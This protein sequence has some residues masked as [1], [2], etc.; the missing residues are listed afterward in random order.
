ME[1]WQHI[2]SHFDPIAFK[3]FFLS[4]HW[5]GIMYALAL[6][7]AVMMASF[8]VKKDKLGISED[9]LDEYIIWA[10]VGVIL[11]A[12]LGYIV[13][14]DPHTYYFLTH[15]W[16][17]FNPF[18]GGTFV[19]IAGM[20]FHGAL[21]G[22]ILATLLYSRKI[23]KK[24]DKKTFWFFVDLAA[25]AVPLGYFFGR[26]GN[27]LNQEL[28]GRVTEV[29]W[30]I[31]VHGVLRHPSQIYEAFLEGVVVFILLYIY[32]NKKKFDGELGILFAI[33]YS[34]ARIIAEF[35]R[36]PDFH[37]GYVYGG[38]ITRGQVLSGIFLIGLMILYAIVYKIKVKKTKN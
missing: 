26:I 37:I 3:L 38:F 28:V 31:Y 12:R 35:W 13:F 24:G 22:Y 8:I 6:L 32:R 27:F 11:G 33:F 19:G 7:V 14:Y 25:L 1:Y 20:S 16:N 9:Q 36:A 29:P 15:P 2:Y 21:L 34:I 30:G 17:I 4:V 10:E 23:S 5:Y 18:V